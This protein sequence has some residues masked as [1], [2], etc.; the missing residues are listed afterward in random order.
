[1]EIPVLDRISY[2]RLMKVVNDVMFYYKNIM[3]TDLDRGLKYKNDTM[4]NVKELVKV[5]ESNIYNSFNNR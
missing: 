2:P 3:V 5:Y 1:M 4:N